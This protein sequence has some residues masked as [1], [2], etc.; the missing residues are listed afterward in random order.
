M[1]VEI[2]YGDRDKGFINLTNVIQMYRDG[3]M[4]VIDMVNRERLKVRDTPEEIF[5][6][7]RL[8]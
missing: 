7:R 5:G 3:D 4:T 6:K 2:T 8:S 1:F